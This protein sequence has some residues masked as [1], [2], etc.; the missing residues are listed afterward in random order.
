MLAFNKRLDIQN[1]RFPNG[2]FAKIPPTQNV[3]QSG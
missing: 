1:Q 2:V 3:P